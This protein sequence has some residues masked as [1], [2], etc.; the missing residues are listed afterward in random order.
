MIHKI[1]GIAD[2]RP[3]FVKE[4]RLPRNEGDVVHCE[5]GRGALR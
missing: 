2:S 5:A 3:Y 1:D 4:R